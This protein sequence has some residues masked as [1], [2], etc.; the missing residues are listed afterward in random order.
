M[1]QPLLALLISLAILSVIGL[2][3]FIPRAALTPTE[4]PLDTLPEVSS[5]DEAAIRSDEIPPA[6]TAEQ[7]IIELLSANPWQ[8]VRSVATSGTETVPVESEAFTIVFTREGVVNGTTDCNSFFSSYHAKGTELS[9]DT[10]GMTKM[11]CEGSQE[12]LFISS[13]SDGGVVTISERD[14]TFTLKQP[15]ITMY[16]TTARPF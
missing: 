1:K 16:F 8:W 4:V 15:D 3:L 7:R 9:F 14:S 2:V 6:F 5:D 12:Q 10:F 11:F 13:L